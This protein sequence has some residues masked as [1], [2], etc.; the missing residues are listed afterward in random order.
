MIKFIRSVA[1]GLLIIM[2]G[3][4]LLNWVNS[5]ESDN[6]ISSTVTYIPAKSSILQSPLSLDS[7]KTSARYADGYVFLDFYD[8]YRL[9]NYLNKYDYS[10]THQ[11]YAEG[12]RYG[13]YFSDVFYL[14]PGDNL[15]IVIYSDV[16][17]GTDL[18]CEISEYKNNGVSGS[19]PAYT[20]ER[21]ENGYRA[22]ISCHATESGEYQFKLWHRDKSQSERCAIVFYFE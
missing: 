13:M 7:L 12:E 15:K 9:S 19:T 18:A 3:L 22:I 5:S 8:P 14:V 16:P 2:A 4:A 20:V 6:P 17:L 21:Y 11:P 10:E 1:T